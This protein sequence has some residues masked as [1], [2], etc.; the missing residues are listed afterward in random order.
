VATYDDG[1]ASLEAQLRGAGAPF[2]AAYD[3]VTSPEDRDYEGLSRRLLRP[4]G[5][6]VAING[7]GTDW[8]RA[9]LGVPRRGH[10][11]HMKQTSGADMAE[12]LG[13][14]KEGRL[15][16]QV[17]EVLPFTEAGVAEAFAKLR[18]RRTKGKLVIRVDGAME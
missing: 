17:E 6:H 5:M 2:D 1:D 13:L 18:S 14:V 9:L 11:I 15:K 10:A 7:S 3:T 16:A 4:S 12:I 8:V